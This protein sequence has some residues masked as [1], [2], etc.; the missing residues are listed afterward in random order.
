MRACQSTTVHRKV[1]TRLVVQSDVCSC[2]GKNAR[3]KRCK[4]AISGQRC[5]SCQ[6][7]KNNRC[8]NT[9]TCIPLSVSSSSSSQSSHSSVLSYSQPL[10]SSVLHLLPFISNE[11]PPAPCTGSNTLQPSQ[12][13]LVQHEPQPQP[14]QLTISSKSTGLTPPPQSTPQPSS[15]SCQPFNHSSVASAVVSI[16]DVARNRTAKASTKSKISTQMTS[17]SA[18]ISSFHMLEG[19]KNQKK[20]KLLQI[21]CHLMVG[22]T[23]QSKCK[24]TAIP[25]IW[26]RL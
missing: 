15:S 26:R 7:F 13:Q 14:P 5:T 21:A 24:G 22:S 23:C 4:C 9:D 19:A 20:T 10:P 11:F 18:S 25:S 2:N 6:P 8:C 1:N 3:C 12:L 16:M 17:K